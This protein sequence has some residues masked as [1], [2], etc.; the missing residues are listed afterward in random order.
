MKVLIVTGGI[1]SGKSEVCRMLNEMYGFPVY[2]ADSRV[3]ELYVTDSCLLEN[4]ECALGQ[5]F[6]SCDGT[7]SPSL[8]SARIFSDDKALSDVEE[9]VFPALMRDFRSWSESHPSDSVLVFESAT[10]LEKE[11]FKGFGDIVLLVDAPVQTRLE[12]ACRRDSSTSD[13]VRMRMS[14]QKLMNL[15]SDKVVEPDVDAVIENDG[16]LSRLKTKVM[17]FVISL[18]E[19]E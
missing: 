13:K 10:I 14:R 17:E 12:R 6:R 1:G 9:L 3:K 5:S 4:I 19:K 16:D 2:D 8:L 7:F 11:C 18:N 15:Y